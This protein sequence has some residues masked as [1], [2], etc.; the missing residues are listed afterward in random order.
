MKNPLI[1][2]EIEEFLEQRRSDDI[3]DFCAEEHPG[4]IAEFLSALSITTLWKVLRLISPSLR[5]EIF[6]HLDEE[7]Q[8]EAAEAVGRA[9]LAQLLSHMPPDDRVDFLRRIPEERREAVLPAM[10]QAEREDIRRLSS[11][12]EGTAGAKM[13]SEYATL[14]PELT[15]DEAIVKLRRAHLSPALASGGNYASKKGT[16]WMPTCSGTAGGGRGSGSSHSF[17]CSGIFRMTSSSSMNA[18]IR[19]GRNTP[20]RSADRPRVKAP[21]GALSSILAPPGCKLSD[22]F[23]VHRVIENSSLEAP[24]AGQVHVSGMFS[25]GVCGGMPLLGSPTVGS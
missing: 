6:S 23:Q 11:Y 2:P 3:R 18:M 22:L 5:S 15:V 10:A 14:R 19:M 8:V 7:V 16:Y 12:P 25:N 13:T 1:A 17:R 21:G 24:Q 9:E 20:G 4:I